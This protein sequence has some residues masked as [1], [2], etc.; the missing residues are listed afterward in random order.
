[1]MPAVRLR[2]GDLELDP[3]SRRARAGERLRNKLGDGWIETVRGVGY[4]IAA[5]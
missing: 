5:A 4:R 1:M 3:L 2:V